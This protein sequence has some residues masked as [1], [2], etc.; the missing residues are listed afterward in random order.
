MSK[1]ISIGIKL[2]HL[3]KCRYEIRNFKVHDW[4]YLSSYCVFNKTIG[5]LIYL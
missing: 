1:D 2:K 3:K 4:R 5:G